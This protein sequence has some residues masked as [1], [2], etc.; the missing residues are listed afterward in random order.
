MYRG[1]M[2]QIYT[3]QELTGSMGMMVIGKKL[4]L[5]LRGMI[6]KDNITIKNHNKNRKI[7]FYYQTLPRLPPQS[8][9][10]CNG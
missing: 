4:W 10:K 1:R 6:G 5:T 7:R 2:D 8:V 3:T 9:T